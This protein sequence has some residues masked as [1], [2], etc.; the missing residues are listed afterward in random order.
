[1]LMPKSASPAPTAC[2]APACVGSTISRSMPASSYQPSSLRRVHAEVV[3][4]RRPVEHE[5]DVAS[6]RSP[7][8]IVVVVAATRGQRRA[9]AT[10]STARTIAA[11]FIA[12]SARRFAVAAVHGVASRPSTLTIAN[13]ARLT[14]ATTTIAA[15]TRSVRN[16]R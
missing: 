6:A 12:F 16:A 2:S 1:M 3:R 11:R 14:S 13:S 7:A 4:V 15:N 5:R 9:R 8:A 10:T